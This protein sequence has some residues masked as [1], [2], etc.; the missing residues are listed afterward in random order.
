MT[1]NFT[2][3]IAATFT[4]FHADGSLN[5]DV[6]P[7][8]VA[9]LRSQHLAGVFVCGT[10]GEGASL[11][12]DERTLVA[13]QWMAA[14]GRELPVTVHV[15]QNSL[16][17]AKSLARHAQQIGANAIAAVAPSFF[18]PAMSELLSFC[19]E[20]AAG[21]PGLP[22]YFYH[23]PSLTGVE[24]SLIEFLKAATDR[25]PNFAGIK[26][27]HEDLDEFERCVATAGARQRML[28][29]RDEMLLS[30][31]E[32]GAHG[33]VGSAYNFTAPMFHRLL[34][35]WRDGD[36]ATAKREQQRAADL[37]TL[38]R[39]YG[40]IPA[41]KA[42]MKLLGVDCGPARLPLRSLP[43]DESAQLREQLSRLGVFD[44]VATRDDLPAP[45][46]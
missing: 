7:G 19:A 41:Q 22:F 3:L 16:E 25:I 5:L 18:R 28:F 9:R 2:G 30:G 34:A 45:A 10:T 6:I 15:G 17:D 11:T 33:A 32:C 27:T 43:D 36:L 31:L 38:L 42:L 8:Y 29:G 23:M 1:D 44:W 46:S 39:G 12:T 4:P 26:Y 37:I 14:V 20:L 21:V 24:C 35:A 13:E 40:L